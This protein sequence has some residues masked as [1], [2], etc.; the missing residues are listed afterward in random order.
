ME[1]NE[2][3]LNIITREKNATPNFQEHYTKI[4][5]SLAVISFFFSETKDVKEL[6]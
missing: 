6:S 3:A 1:I 4:D 2:G 5:V